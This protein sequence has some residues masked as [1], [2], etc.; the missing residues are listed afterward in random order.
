M[1]YYND[2]SMSYMTE[3][4]KKDMVRFTTIPFDFTVYEAYLETLVTCELSISKYPKVFVNCLKELAGVVYPLLNKQTYR[5]IQNNYQ[6]TNRF[7]NNMNDTL[8]KM[9]K[10]Y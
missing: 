4:F 2:P 7:S 6:S 9:K 10:Q 5:P 1:A 8:E 3:L